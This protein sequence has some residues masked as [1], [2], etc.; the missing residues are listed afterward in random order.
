M[1][2]SGWCW[3]EGCLLLYT[4]SDRL[5]MLATLQPFLSAFRTLHPSENRKL[6]GP[7]GAH[8]RSGDGDRSLFLSVVA[9]TNG[10][11]HAGLSLGQE[12]V[13]EDASGRAYA[14]TSCSRGTSAWAMTAR[15]F[16]WT[17]GSS[18]GTVWFARIHFVLSRARSTSVFEPSA[19]QES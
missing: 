1:V 12:T 2:P 19:A 18:G 6:P 8:E 10:R 13:F 15:S 9:G 17:T 16:V 14:T 7:G 11:A 3:L 5:N 4:I